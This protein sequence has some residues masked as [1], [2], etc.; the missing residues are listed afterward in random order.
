M[1]KPGLTHEQHTDIGK[2]LHDIREQLIKI[3]VDV[4]NAYPRA[5]D[6]GRPGRKLHT[7]LDAID[8]ARSDL[9]SALFNE[10]PAQADTHTY[11]PGT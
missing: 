9:D 6:R 1:A 2:Q 11:Y 3:A 7:A 5:G 4:A 10:H 8:T